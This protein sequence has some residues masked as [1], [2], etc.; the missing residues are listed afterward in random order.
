MGFT[1]YLKIICITGLLGAPFSGPKA[2][3]PATFPPLPPLQNGGTGPVILTVDGINQYVE[4]LEKVAQ[5]INEM[6]TQYKHFQD[7]IGQI[8]KYVNVL[9]KFGIS[10]ANN[11]FHATVVDDL[12]KDY[13]INN[14]YYNV[15]QNIGLGDN[16]PSQIN[17]YFKFFTEFETAYNNLASLAKGRILSNLNIVLNAQSKKWLG[18]TTADTVKGQL[19][20]AQN[21]LTGLNTQL[22]AAQN[23]LD[24][25]QTE[26]TNTKQSITN[27]NTN[28][29]TMQSDLSAEEAKE[30]T[31]SEKISAIDSEISAYKAAYA[32]YPNA[33]KEFDAAKTAFQNAQTNKT[34]TQN[35]PQKIQ[36]LKAKISALKSTNAKL[37]T[38]NKENVQNNEKIVSLTKQ[39]KDLVSTINVLEQKINAD[40]TKLS[41]AEMMGDDT[42]TT[43]TEKEL[44]DLLNKLGS[45]KKQRTAIQIQLEALT[46]KLISGK[47]TQEISDNKSK[48]TTLTAQIKSLQAQYDAAQTEYADALKA[49]DAKQSALQGIESTLKNDAPGITGPALS[50]VNTN[51][52]NDKKA[53]NNDE[54]VLATD[55]RN[56]RN[57]Q[58]LLATL[59]SKIS[60]ASQQ[61]DQLTSQKQALENQISIYKNQLAAF[62]ALATLQKDYISITNMHQSLKNY[63]S[64]IYKDSNSLYAIVK[65]ILPITT[66]KMPDSFLRAR[67]GSGNS[68]Y[69]SSLLQTLNA[70]NSSST[71][72]SCYGCKTGGSTA[73]C[74]SSEKVTFTKK[75]CCGFILHAKY[76]LPFRSLINGVAAKSSGKTSSAMPYSSLP[77]AAQL[78]EALF[79]S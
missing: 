63:Q 59:P 46:N 40:Y 49:Y 55:Q 22:S 76:Y 43:V 20:Q 77:T 61:V 45:D 68:V 4:G 25:L 60:K 67:P 74:N 38:E 58:A 28:I 56:L 71:S 39:L 54:G 50:T 19:A 42:S 1:D 10:V 8:V 52:N 33:Q 2:D 70:C 44:Q 21:K 26:M 47:L 66:L 30:N 51:L 13:H 69:N 17:N 53:I 48:I 41:D 11:Q 5:A 73:S 23:T 3:V 65:R 78:T 72:N 7:N 15:L 75:A 14:F 31:D 6:Y 27:I 36:A 62:A 32:Q 64:E 24:Q 79:G 16:T 9:N 34:N 37:E 29:P 12:T 35:Y 57:Y 18:S